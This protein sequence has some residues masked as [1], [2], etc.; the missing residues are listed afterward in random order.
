MITVDQP[1]FPAL[2]INRFP[3]FDQ[4]ADALGLSNLQ[5]ESI[6]FDLRSRQLDDN[7]TVLI[8]HYADPDK[9]HVI[10][11]EEDIKSRQVIV[12]I[13]RKDLA[14]ETPESALRNYEGPPGDVRGI[15]VHDRC[16]DRVCLPADFL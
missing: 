12:L 7:R 10:L 9:T 1:Y 16:V 6:L 15:R 11:P 14:A 5:L 4:A 2:V 3:S 8:D 13:G